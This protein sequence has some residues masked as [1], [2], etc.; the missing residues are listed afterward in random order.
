MTAWT[1]LTVVVLNFFLDPPTSVTVTPSPIVVEEGNAITATC[2]A[3]GN[4]QPTFK[5]FRSTDLVNPI[6]NDAV[7]NVL[8]AQESDK[9]SY[10]CR[11]SNKFGVNDAI[12]T[13]DVQCK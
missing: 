13:A 9:G 12:V 5:W 10:L 1:G 6:D 8:N 11:A 3:T 2:T 7:L 4:P